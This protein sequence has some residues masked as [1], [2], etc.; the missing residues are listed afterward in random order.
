[1]NAS[2]SRILPPTVTQLVEWV[3]DARVRTLELIADL[4]DE[5]ILGVPS[6]TVNPL[7]WEIGHVAWFQEKWVLRHFGGRRPLHDA[8]DALYDSAAIA[9][10]TRWD[11]P[12][13]SREVTLTYLR[14]TRDAVLD[15]LESCDEGPH[16]DLAYFVKLSVF[17]EDMHTEAFTSTRQTLGYP[18]PRLALPSPSSPPA[19]PLPG[20]AYVPSG[21]FYLGA[22]RDEPFVFD[23]EKW[24]HRADVKPF[25][26]ARAPVTQ[27]EY[28]AFVDDRGYERD[29]LWCAEGWQWRKTAHANHPLYWE[30]AA[31]DG[32][33]RRHF[34]RWMDLEPHHPMIHVNWFEADAFCRWAGRR[35]PTELEWEVSASAEPDGRDGL[36]ADQRRYP[37]GDGCPTE[38]CANLDGR[39]GGCVEVGCRQ[40]GDSAFALRQMF[41]NVWE[42]TSGEFLPYPGFVPDPYK[43]YSQPWF[44]THKVLRGGS[45]ATRSRLLRNTWRN[46]FTPDRRDI[47]AGFRTCAIDG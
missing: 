15:I 45:W 32:W 24:A 6:P 10:D 30:R 37:W 26:I 14:Q 19:G 8:A 43:E 31:Y 17:H 47:F 13:P 38:T 1:M 3:R 29:T 22:R 40:D 2:V 23:N 21:V 9:H 41:G 27:A 35:L 20:D 16:P 25:S 4:S 12:L 39:A 28:A 34:D 46:F 42:W 11:L 5:Q 44:G 18:Q 36:S 33:L 7:L